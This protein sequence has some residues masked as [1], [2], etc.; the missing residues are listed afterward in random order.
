MEG[1]IPTASSDGVLSPSSA[2]KL[3]K[4]RKPRAKPSASDSAPAGDVFLGNNVHYD[5]QGRPLCSCSSKLCNSRPIVGYG[6]CKLHILEDKSAPFKQCEAIIKGRGCNFAIALTENSRFCGIHQS[7]EK[8]QAMATQTVPTDPAEPLAS[9]STPALIVPKPIERTTVVPMID[10]EE[11][12]DEEDDDFTPTYFSDLDDDTATASHLST[13]MFPPISR[14]HFFEDDALNGVEEATGGGGEDSTLVLGHPSFAIGTFL[15]RR[16]EKLLNLVKKYRMR[17]IALQLAH[18]EHENDLA[19]L[20]ARQ[21]ARLTNEAELVNQHAER[22]RKL[23]EKVYRRKYEEHLQQK[24]ASESSSSSSA[25]H[26]ASFNFNTQDMSSNI[27]GG[28][29]ELDMESSSSDWKMGEG[30]KRDASSSSASH[31]SS[32]SRRASYRETGPSTSNTSLSVST[33]ASSSSSTKH[34]NRLVA[35]VPCTFATCSELSLPLSKYCWCHILHDPNQQLFVACSHTDQAGKRCEYPIIKYAEPPM[36]AY[37]SEL[38][39]SASVTGAVDV[40]DVEE[41]VGE[42][43]EEEEEDGEEG[44]LADVQI[45]D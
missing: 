27:G 26:Q 21:V 41:D 38:L 9:S 33:G 13:T 29:S 31:A 34:A 22:R 32:S 4:P 42:E 5:F 15:E 40:I 2:G 7:V 35:P 12:T 19:M 45:A 23:L 14:T 36:C 8:R 16:A 20:R 43:E 37:H 18:E 3:K 6:F 24:K 11:Y 28:G 30:E 1:I 25:P 44:S 10:Q 39:A 17:I